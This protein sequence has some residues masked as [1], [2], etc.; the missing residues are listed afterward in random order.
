MSRRS[1]AKH[2][3][4]VA[5]NQIGGARGTKNQRKRICDNFISWCFLRGYLF[6]S[7]KEVTL[8]MLQEYFKVLQLEGIT[9]A[10]QHN[11]LSAIL[12]TIKMLQPKT[13]ASTKLKTEPVIFSV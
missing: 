9:V 10:T 13:A 6:N 11:R 4:T 7:M 5:A 2:S 12:K 3:V 1:Q 8:E